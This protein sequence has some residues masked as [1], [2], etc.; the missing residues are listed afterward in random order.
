MPEENN[1]LNVEEIK[2]NII[3]NN[4]LK[5]IKSS[6]IKQGSEL[7]EID[8]ENVDDETFE[9]NQDSNNKIYELNE[10]EV[11]QFEEFHNKNIN[12]EFND[13]TESRAEYSKDYEKDFWLII[14]MLNWIIRILIRNFTLK[15]NLNQ[16]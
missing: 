1:N 8:F 10:S 2:E 11:A 7:K 15:M 5:N 16:Q 6:Q 3:E 9:V 4:A 14:M 12:H 13:Q